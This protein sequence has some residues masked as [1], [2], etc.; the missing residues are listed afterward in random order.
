QVNS[1]LVHGPR[2]SY[3]GRE[4]LEETSLDL[5]FRVERSHFRRGDLK[6]KCLASIATVYWK[7]NEESVE[8]ERP[9]RPPV[10]EVKDNQPHWSRADRVQ[11]DQSIY[12]SKTPPKPTDFRYIFSRMYQLF[13]SQ[14]GEQCRNTPAVGLRHSRPPL[15]HR[16]EVA[17]PGLKARWKSEEFVGVLKDVI[18][19]SSILQETVYFLHFFYC[20]IQ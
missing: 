9:Q 4:G 11:G 20:E 6:L 14:H 3:I 5:D 16:N 18:D 10:L 15:L 13:S 17:D 7:S 1:S 12:L 8:G 2:I 19:P